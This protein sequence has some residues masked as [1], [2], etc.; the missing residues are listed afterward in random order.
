VVRGQERFL[1]EERITFYNAA[2]GDVRVAE[3]E[4]TE[5]LKQIKRPR[6][7][8]NDTG[9]FDDVFQ[10]IGKRTQE[11]IT[12]IAG[13]ESKKAVLHKVYTEE[14]G[15]QNVAADNN[16][17]LALTK[18]AAI[19]DN[20]GWDHLHDE[21]NSVPPT[22]LT[23]EVI[24]RFRRV[25][26]R[27]RKDDIP[28][29]EENFRRLLQ[30]NVIGDFNTF[31]TSL[32]NMEQTIFTRISVINTHLAKVA[33]DRRQGLETYIRLIPEKTRDRV[34]HDFRVELNTALK[35]ILN[36]DEDSI[37]SGK[38]AYRGAR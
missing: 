25:E 5:N 2:I 32:E 36:I 16:S 20:P 15:Q 33:F 24:A 29:N 31:R 13:I 10:A 18:R 34:V 28:K 17:N 1:Y 19:I 11:P 4:E 12:D 35:D 38:F 27:I 26:T 6:P 21:L 9:A 23:E 7:L 14:I 3:H 8:T 37:P 22:H 30:E